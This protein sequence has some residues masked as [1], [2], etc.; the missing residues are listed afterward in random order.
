MAPFPFGDEWLVIAP[1]SSGGW[2]APYQD[3]SRE[4]TGVGDVNGDGYA[5]VVALEG[6]SLRIFLGSP[7]GVRTDPVGLLTP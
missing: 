7:A 3:A 2:R 6:T 1:G 4:F 5:D